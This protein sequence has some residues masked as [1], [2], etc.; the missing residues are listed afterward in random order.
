MENQC[1]S[2]SL[3]SFYIGKSMQIS[4][5]KL[6]LYRKT[7]ANF[8]NKAH[9]ILENQCKMQSFDQFY[10]SK[11]QFVELFLKKIDWKIKPFYTLCPRMRT[12][13]SIFWTWIFSWKNEFEKFSALEWAFF[14]KLQ[15]LTF[16]AL[17]WA[18][19]RF[20]IVKNV[21]LSK[22]FALVY[23]WILHWLSYIKWA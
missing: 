15:F 12:L 16:S 11:I 20:P 19:W 7:N 22:G 13:T 21:C 18:F 4:L 10:T 3:R 14:R 2:H 5:T 1:K 8:T 17:G 23:D 6:I 9:F